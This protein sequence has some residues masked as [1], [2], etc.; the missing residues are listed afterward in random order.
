MA[1]VH[2]SSGTDA[3]EAS[4]LAPYALFSKASR[5]RMHPE[6]AHPLRTAFQRD[7]DRVV[8][9]TAFRRLEYKTQVFVTGQGDHFRTRLTHTI[10]V[11][12][13]TRTIA[14]ALRLNEDLA[15]TVALAH[16]LGHPPFGHSGETALN[17]LLAD[18]G[19]FD[20]NDQ[21]LKIV[22]ELEEKYPNFMGLNLTVEVREGLVKHRDRADGA[23]LDGR[24]LSTQL[25][26]EAQVADVADDLTYFSHD[27][28]DGIAA[29]LIGEADL[30]DITVWA[31]ARDR[32]ASQGLNAE[33]GS[34]VPFIIRNLVDMLVEDVIN[35][36]AAR[37]AAAGLTKS[38]DAEQMDEQLLGFSDEF[39]DLT[40]DLRS[41]LFERMYYH[42]SVKQDN[43][44]AVEWMCALYRYLVAHPEELG[45]KSSK[46]VDRVGLERA[47]ADH[48]AGMTDR[49]A[50]QE[51]RNK[52][53]GSA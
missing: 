15:E 47:V 2:D 44:T 45:R 13:V 14:R 19:G 35:A 18:H 17:E 31:M 41:F 34:Y 11:A 12:G 21:A 30:K 7:R 6:P 20:H 22:D 43:D 28:D 39:R 32:A 50:I 27:L 8:H 29:G 24:A 38:G 10:E 40:R 4:L 48:I 5:G 16:D 36:S 9:S 53:L 52:V 49:Y 51:Y 37:L 1:K 23:M 3:L 25:F 46:R 42:P 33:C 26:L